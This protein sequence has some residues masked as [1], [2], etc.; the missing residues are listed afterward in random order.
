MKAVGSSETSI[1]L[2]NIIQYNISKFG[3]IQTVKTYQ[4]L[5]Y[6]RLSSIEILYTTHPVE[7][8]KC[9]SRLCLYPDIGYVPQGTH[10]EQAASVVSKDYVGLRKP[11]CFTYP[12]CVPWLRE[13]RRR[14]CTPRVYS[15]CC[16]CATG[17][18]P[19]LMYTP[20]NKMGHIRKLVHIN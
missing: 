13:V 17:L 11:T 20:E 3:N 19:R 2:C 12:H 8:Q 9:A 15:L 4:V 1:N 6:R 16:L 5:R 10:S 14:L 18:S 7:H